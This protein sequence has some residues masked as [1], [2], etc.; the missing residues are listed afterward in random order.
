MYD[1]CL[2]FVNAYTHTTRHERHDTPNWEFARVGEDN[3]FAI[4]I[5]F[6]FFLYVIA[7]AVLFR[8]SDRRNQWGFSAVIGAR[9]V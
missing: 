4:I 7:A 1:M 8:S 9:V 3:F 2:M 5:N 6:F